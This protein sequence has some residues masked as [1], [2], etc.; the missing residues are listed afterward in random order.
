MS[1]NPEGPSLDA[2]RRDFLMTVESYAEPAAL[3]HAEAL[4][5]ALVGWSEE[6]PALE[7]SRA[8]LKQTVGY[9]LGA[10]G[11]VLW[12]AH[13]KHGDEPVLVLLPTLGL[14]LEFDDCHALVRDVTALPSRWPVEDAGAILIPFSSLGDGPARSALTRLLDA[15]VPIAQRYA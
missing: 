3:Q 13:P 5:D 4:L 12:V 11:P 14:E 8:G 7:P 1:W 9:R 6:H 2:R 10:E 15:L